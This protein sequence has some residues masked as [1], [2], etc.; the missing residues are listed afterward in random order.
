MEFEDSAENFMILLSTE[1]MCPKAAQS[2]FRFLGTIHGGKL[3][4]LLDSRS[5]HYFLNANVV[6]A[7]PGVQSLAQPLSITVANGNNLQCSSELPDT[8]WEVQ[9]LSFKSTFK[10]IPLPCYDA[11]LGM[12]WL[13][14]FSPMFVD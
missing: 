2:T 3:L 14:A 1:A 12:D 11:I 5:S 9:G 10:L 8:D 7:I 6:D 13:Q 4:M